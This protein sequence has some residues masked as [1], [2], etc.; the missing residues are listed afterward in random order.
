M[1]LWR[2]GGRAEVGRYLGSARN[3][4]WGTSGDLE[5][6]CDEAFLSSGREPRIHTMG[7]ISGLRVMRQPWGSGF[8]TMGFLATERVLLGRPTSRA[9][10]RQ[11]S[12][13]AVGS[14]IN[15]CCWW[16]SR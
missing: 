16:F 1:W 3:G 4:V 10:A 7:G 6:V 5:F 12:S 2:S 8:E 14:V 15:S 13:T 9:I 11:G